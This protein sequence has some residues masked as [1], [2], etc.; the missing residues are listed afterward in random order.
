MIQKKKVIVPSPTLDCV[1]QLIIDKCSANIQTDCGGKKISLWV[2]HCCIWKRA[3]S[4]AGLHQVTLTVRTAYVVNS[5]QLSESSTASG[6][7]CCSGLTS[8]RI[9]S[10]VTGKKN[11]RACAVCFMQQI[12]GVWPK[13][14]DPL[15]NR[16]GKRDLKHRQTKTN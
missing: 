3:P 13:L 16:K 12:A 4:L 1:K 8:T 6:G 11:L 2:L 10:L 7:L 14:G 9:L 15:W 5:Q